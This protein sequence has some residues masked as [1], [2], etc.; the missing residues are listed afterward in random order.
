LR[1]LPVVYA[2]LAE[3]NP[4]A[5]TVAS[6]IATGFRRLDLAEGDAAVAIMLPWQGEPHYTY[7]RALAE[8]I[9]QAT[10]HALTAGLPLVIA[11][12]GDIASSLG[13]IL[14]EDVGIR[15][16]LVA[17]DG[18]QLVELDYVDIGELMQPANV[19]AVVVKSLAFGGALSHDR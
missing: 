10:P 7:L 14:V 11:L 17:I 19:V 16:P 15:V 12:D 1:N 4:S 13:G 18:L 2:R 6:A 9:A 5:A 3:A 8:G